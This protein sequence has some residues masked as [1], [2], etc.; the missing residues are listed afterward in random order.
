MVW[1]ERFGLAFASG[2]FPDTFTLAVRTRGDHGIEWRNNRLKCYE[3]SMLVVD[4]HLYLVTDSGVA[5]CLHAADGHELWKQRLG[6]KFSSSPVRIDGR[7]YVTNERGT[8]YVFAATP[9]AYESLGKNQLG[10]ECFATPT[11]VGRLLYHRFAVGSGAARKEYL[12]A[13]GP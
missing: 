11:P 9:R 13:I 2:G 4:D 6:G 8:T 1:H 7:I 10:D 5:Y 3:Q 12:A